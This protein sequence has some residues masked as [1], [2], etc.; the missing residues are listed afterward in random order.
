MSLL[1]TGRAGY[2]LAGPGYSAAVR[3]MRVRVLPALVLIVALVG[4]AGCGRDDDRANVRAVTDRFFAAVEAGDGDL[5]CQ[6]LSPITRSELESQEQRPCREAVTRLGLEGGSVD[7]V[8]VYVRNAMVDLS[9]GD[10][11]FLSQGDEG[12]RLSALGCTPEAGNP[13]DSPY[14]CELQD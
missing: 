1:P 3:P 12:W 9:T 14:D 8:Q 10:A 5:A 7:R 4:V 2:H 13:T 6:Q 11:A